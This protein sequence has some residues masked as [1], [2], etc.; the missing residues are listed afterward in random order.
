M[1]KNEPIICITDLCNQKCVF[2][3][4][5]G[6][7]PADSPGRIKKLINMFKDSICVEGGEP[8]LAKD[9]LK[10]VDYARKRGTDDII[11]VTNGTNLEKTG[12]V[13]DLLKAGVTMFNVQIPAHNAR[14]F[15]AMTRTS[16]NFEKRVAA[17]RNLIAVAGAVRVRLT[18]V[19]N[20]LIGRFLP[21]Y[22]K[23]VAV[24]FPGIFYIEINMVK[25]LGHVESRTWLVP[26]LTDI[27]PG[28]I[29]AF[30]IF[31]KSGIKFLTD[32]FPLCLTRGYE[33]RAI[34]TFKLGHVKNTL[35]L[36]EKRHCAVCE[37]C[38]L[39]DLCPGLRTDYF[40]LYGPAELKASRKDPA[41]IIKRA[42][43]Q[44]Q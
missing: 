40:N 43:N 41:P 13:K 29:K 12:F 20:S 6:H 30:K 32:G 16:N 36:G 39:K 5:G 7:T 9:L 21:Q 44:L 22:A 2:C 34:D 14:L 35:Y 28:L 24:N 17:V 11:L 23:F 37:K 8:V 10:W 27:R 4:R 42:A 33:D 1:K 18:L 25:V 3:S 26:R 31:D 15:D 19:V 38:R